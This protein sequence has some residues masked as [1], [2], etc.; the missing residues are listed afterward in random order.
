MV[1]GHQ[2]VLMILTESAAP[3][4]AAGLHTPAAF[5]PTNC[6]GCRA[7]GAHAGGQAREPA[8]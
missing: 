6:A 1:R 8:L 5:P 3:L 4:L 7:H 2:G